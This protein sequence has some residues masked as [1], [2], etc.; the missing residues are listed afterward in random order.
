MLHRH[1]L[2]AIYSLHRHHHLQGLLEIFM[3]HHLEEWAR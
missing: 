1:H 3:R 2:L